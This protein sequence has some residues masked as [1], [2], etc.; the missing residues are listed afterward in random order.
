MEIVRKHFI[1]KKL[2]MVFA[3]NE[4]FWNCLNDSFV[5]KKGR[6]RVRRKKE[7]EKKILWKWMLQKDVKGKH[8]EYVLTISKRKSRVPKRRRRGKQTEALE[9]MS[10]IIIEWLEENEKE[11]VCLGQWLSTSSVIASHPAAP[12]LI[13]GIPKICVH[14]LD[15]GEINQLGWLEESYRLDNAGWLHLVL[16]I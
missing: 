11:S 16:I 13:V 5:L 6:K 7:V 10:K 2:S 12:G 9:M 15:V 4:I 8:S 3:Q 1:G 14:D